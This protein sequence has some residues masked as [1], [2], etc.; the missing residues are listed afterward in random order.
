MVSSRVSSSP[1]TA[2]VTKL[3]L[4][5]FRSTSTVAVDRYRAGSDQ[6][7]ERHAASATVNTP[8]ASQ[9]RRFHTST[10]RFHP[11]PERL[12]SVI[13][14]HS[15]RHDDNV[16]GLQEEVVRGGRVRDDLVVV[17]R[18]PLGRPTILP[19]DDDARERG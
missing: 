8:V 13:V 15:S 17:D 1:V 5:S 19:D 16:A 4:T 10:A 11:D 12:K 9:R 6:M 14:P 7:K 18:D 2:D 3:W